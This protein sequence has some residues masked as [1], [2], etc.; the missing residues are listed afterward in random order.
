M[1]NTG[2]GSGLCFQFPYHRA[3]QTAPGRWSTEGGQRLT[4]APVREVLTPEC[5]TTTHSNTPQ[6]EQR[7]LHSAGKLWQ[8]KSPQLESVIVL[9]QLFTPALNARFCFH[10]QRSLDQVE[11]RTKYVKSCQIKGTAALAAFQTFNP[12]WEIF[13]ASS[14]TL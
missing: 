8:E 2:F 9:G 6:L 13:V 1:T 11:T 4:A 10:N 5:A 12:L 14:S 7:Q 3:E